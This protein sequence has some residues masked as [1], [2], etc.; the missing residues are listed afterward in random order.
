MAV[1]VD[2]DGTLLRNGIYPIKRMVDWV[3]SQDTVYIV[4]ARPEAAR[5]STE[6]ALKNAGIKYNRLLMNSVGRSHADGLESKK[7]NGKK[8]KSQVSYAVDNDAD[9][10]AAYES[11][12]ISTKSP[13]DVS[14][15]NWSGS[16]IKFK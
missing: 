9:A 16:F 1:I 11:V 7:I 13:G 15:F 5:Q 12:G 2:I 4:T 8:L 14:K 6:R 3:N 10:R